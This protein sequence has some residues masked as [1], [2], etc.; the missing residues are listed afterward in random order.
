MV[1][2][3]RST[4]SVPNARPEGGLRQVWN[5]VMSFINRPSPTDRRALGGL[6]VGGAALTGVAA[7]TA[8]VTL[9]LTAPALV[10]SAAVFGG[11]AAF[12]A[13]AGLGTYYLSTST[14]STSAR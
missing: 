11:I 3:S 5:G 4:A 9:P 8:L 6:L 13:L 1:R 14:G 12:M 7:V 10:V 2:A